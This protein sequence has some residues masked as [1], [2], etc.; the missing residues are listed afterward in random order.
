MNTLLPLTRSIL[1]ASFARFVLVAP[2]RRGAADTGD[3]L[4]DATQSTADTCVIVGT[5]TVPD[6]SVLRFEKPN[7][8][9]RG[10]VLVQFTGRCELDSTI[11][12]ASDADCAAAGSCE[13]TAEMTLVVGGLLTVELHGEISARGQAVAG[14]TIGPDGGNI[15]LD[16]HDL[17]LAGVVSVTAL[18]FNGIP[19]GHA[20]GI[21]VNADG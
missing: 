4:C 7:V 8:R 17:S 21:V 15:T 12:C 9:V 20:G 13:R 18:G 1:L 14:D 19:A 6:Q 11:A 10:R 5:S 16:T 3:F 2:Q